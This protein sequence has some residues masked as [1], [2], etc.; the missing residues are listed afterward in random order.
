MAVPHISRSDKYDQ[1]QEPLDRDKQSREEE[2]RER[3]LSTGNNDKLE[4][5]R[6]EPCDE[7][8]SNVKERL[9]LNTFVIRELGLGWL[10]L[11]ASLVAA[12]VASIIG[13]R[14]LV[15]VH[16]FLL[17]FDSVIDPVHQNRYQN[18]DEP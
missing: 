11:Q 13:D 3:E 15:L 1:V 12:F 17:N 8:G 6:E 10:P 4:Y 18:N 5:C 14:N 16:R 9:F 2:K 7:E